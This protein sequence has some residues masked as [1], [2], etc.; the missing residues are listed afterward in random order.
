MRPAGRR[1]AAGVAAGLMLAAVGC[2][3]KGPPA[4]APGSAPASG[5]PIAV[6]LRDLKPTV[7]MDATAQSSPVFAV[8]APTA[9]VLSG[10]PAAGAAVQAGQQVALIGT[11]PI[12]SP[13][14]GVVVGPLADAG[15]S[16]PA[17]LP[18]VAIRYAGFAL[19]GAPEA[20][21]AGPLGNSDLTARGQVTNGAGPFDC[22]ALVPSPG[23]APVLASSAGD[24]ATG[25][26][27]AATAA[28]AAPQQGAAW[29]CLVPK[30]VTVPDGASGVVVAVA[31]VATQVI[32]VPLTAVAG[33]TG[34]GQVTR[35]TAGGTE[36]AN[37]KLG[38][39]DGT[40]VEI[41]EGLAVGDRI[42]PVAPDL[43]GKSA[44]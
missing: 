17:G 3:P 16:V 35:I 4:Y 9:G 29:M 27:A 42:S 26:D 43:S 11:A 40:Y 28:P 20:W 14:A 24:T 39:T 38:R 37:V 13:V 21:R 2:T 6:A 18:V 19:V 32:A 41:T 34:S 23:T 44:G 15:Q 36:T 10:M 1:V 31:T 33:R 5:Q 30:D 25:S 22:V 7:S 12:T 8:T